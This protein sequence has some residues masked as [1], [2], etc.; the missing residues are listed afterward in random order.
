MSKSDH[1]TGGRVRSA[2]GRAAGSYVLVVVV[3]VVVGLA[4]APFAWGVAV[5][6]SPSVAVVPI[7]GTIDGSNAADVN[8]RLIE[9]REDPSIEAVV[10]VINSG[11]GTAADS[12]EIHLQIDRTAEEMPVV[13]VVDAAGLSGAY[14]AAAPSDRIYAK[15]AT[16]VGS[17]GTQ[18]V[19]VPPTDPMD[20]VIASGPDKLDGQTPRGW[21]HMT[22]TTSNAF[23]EVV[24]EHRGEELELSRE[25]LAHAKIYNGVDGIEKGL[26]DDFGDLTRGVQSAAEMA[27]LDPGDYTLQTLQYD[28]EVQ[29]IS[30]TTYAAADVSEKSLVEPEEFVDPDRDDPIPTVLL[31]PPTTFADGGT[32]NGTAVDHENDEPTGDRA[33]DESTA[34]VEVGG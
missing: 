3:A 26:V 9:A 8:Q 24:V 14:K 33:I 5:E 15:P 11:G 1:P 30:Q 21:E 29:F 34:T 25:E 10:L 22:E 12:D 4:I 18:L 19:T 31:V 20:D 6:P 2:V 7:A 17:V 27:D 28:T 13:A 16:M 23:L 32:A